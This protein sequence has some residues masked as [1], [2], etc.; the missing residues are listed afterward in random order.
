[1]LD[2]DLE[3]SSGEAIVT[4]MPRATPSTRFVRRLGKDIRRTARQRM[5][6]GPSVPFEEMV[7][8]LR[9]MVRLLHKTLVPVQ[10]RS[11]FASLLGEQLYVKASKQVAVRHRRLRWLMFGGL[12][13]SILSLLGLVAAILLRRRNG[14]L[15]TNKPIGVA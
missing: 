14:R 11:S 15:H 10:P 5:G 12:V 3:N 4:F 7:I 8:E 1:M 9:K 2:Q 13:G 6:Y